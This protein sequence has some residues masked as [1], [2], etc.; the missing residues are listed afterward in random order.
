MCCPQTFFYL[1]SPRG[2]IYTYRRRKCLRHIHLRC[3]LPCR[4]SCSVLC[5]PY[6]QIQTKNS[7][8]FE[9]FLC[10]TC[11]KCLFPSSP[12]VTLYWK[13]E[14]VLRQLRCEVHPLCLLFPHRTKLNG[15]Y[16]SLPHESGK[17]SNYKYERNQEKWCVFVNKIK[18]NFVTICAK[19]GVKFQRT[20]CVW[21]GVKCSNVVL[22]FGWGYFRS[23]CAAWGPQSGRW[24]GGIKWHRRGSRV[25]VRGVEYPEISCITRFMYNTTPHVQTW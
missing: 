19:K 21:C 3:H 16:W 14:A 13:P 5:M 15:T 22:N 12:C 1:T 7:L 9:P 6:L 18:S 10:W 4:I 17:C 23:S 8:C 25:L 2:H 20:S 24:T 11:S